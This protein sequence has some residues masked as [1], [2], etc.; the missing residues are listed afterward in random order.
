MAQPPIFGAT[1]ASRAWGGRKIDAM[2]LDLPTLRNTM[3]AITRLGAAVCLGLA[4]THASAAEFPSR[5]VRMIVPFAA[6]GV[7][8]VL[9]RL[10]SAGL[11]A[12]MPKGVIVENRVGAGGDIGGEYVY[13]SDP[14][15]Q[16][17]LVSS[18]GP[19]A[20]DQGLY[21]KLPFDPTKWAPIAIL[22]SVPNALIVSPTLPVKTAQEF[23]AYV[24][25]HPGRVSYAT[26]GNGTTSHLTAKLFESLTGSQMIQVPYKGDAPALTDLAGSQVDAFFG[27]VGASLALHRA[28]KVRILA[29]A[30]A[31]RAAAL[32]DVP[33][34]A[35][36][37]LPG[38]KS[39]TWYAMV[40]PPATPLATR[41]QLGAW[42]SN[43]MA[44]T[45]TQQ[46]LRDLGLDPV[47]LSIDQTTSF[48]REETARWQKVI[49][50]A[51][52]KLE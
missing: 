17:L 48:L 19:I 46:K 5:V 24:K 8:D 44:D 38:M 3:K 16:T 37:G 50:D 14:D 22:A 2:N 9:A 13:R 27:N 36:V 29:V 11:Q 10:A 26:Q 47:S 15:G 23:V 39:I 43:A 52:V 7:A 35:E 34:F 42:V 18:P 4:L 31:R 30:D 28:G 12:D 33:T 51:H 41:T 40:A 45:A 21:P 32:P 25:A 49:R 1:R 20:I 6:G